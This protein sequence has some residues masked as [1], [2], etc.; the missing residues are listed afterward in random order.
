MIV[1]NIKHHQINS[2]YQ[3][4][5]SYHYDDNSSLF[6][7]FKPYAHKTCGWKCIY[8][9]ATEDFE[10]VRLLVVCILS[11]M[12]SRCNIFLWE[13]PAG[14]FFIIFCYCVSY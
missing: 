7:I 14:T 6:S 2:I 9:I 13:G 4:L 8:Q 1:S 5:A 10:V 3:Y 11:L 12:N